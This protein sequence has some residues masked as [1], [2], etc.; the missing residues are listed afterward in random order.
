MDRMEGIDKMD[1]I[2]LGNTN[3]SSI[4]PFSATEKK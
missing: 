1:K 2:D 3:I 4:F